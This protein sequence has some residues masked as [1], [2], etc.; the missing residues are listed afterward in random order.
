MSSVAGVRDA[1]PLRPLT[2]PPPDG[3]WSGLLRERCDE[4]LADAAVHAAALKEAPRGDLRVLEIWNDLQIDLGAAFAASTLFAE[5]HP[6]P[7]V[8]A[9][10]ERARQEAERFQ[11]DLMLDADV[12]DQLSLLDPVSLEQ[13]DGARRVVDK[14]LQD[15]RRA[16]V[17][18]DKTTRDR[19]RAI[20]EREVELEQAFSRGIREGTRTTRVPSSALAGLPEDW[21]AEHPV[22]DDGLVEVSSHYPD[23]FPFLTYSADAAARLAVATAHLNVGWPDN[24]PVLQELLTLRREHA[25]LLGYPDWPSFDAETKMIG[26]GDAIPAFIDRIVEATGGT[27]AKEIDRLRDL[28]ARHGEPDLVIDSSNWRYWS[29]RLRTEEYDVDAHEV[30]SYFDFAR[31]RQ[32]LLDVTGRLFGLTYAAVPDAPVWHAEVTAYDV[33]MD[34]DRVGRIYLDLHPRPGKYNHAAQFDLVRG[35]AGRHL[36]EGVLVCN[37]PRGQMEHS[38]VVTLFHEFGHLL[39]H[40][41]GGHTDWAR[42]SGVATEWDFVEAPSQMLEEWAWAPEV[43]STF[44]TDAEGRAIPADLVRRMRAAHDF[45]KGFLARQQMFYALVSY[46]FHQ[47]VPDD[48]TARMREIAR[49]VN[50]IALPDDTHF[51]AGFGHLEGYT[52]AYYTYMWSLVIAK[53]LFSAFDPEDLFDPAVAHRYRDK[54]LVPG[55]SRDAADLVRDFLGRP[56]NADAFERWIAG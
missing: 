10:A 7:D 40:V 51:H 6:D 16:G 48:L 35:V 2:L 42:F 36:P 43:L 30:R 11:T 18:R 49:E 8:R 3:D 1:S 54:V 17:D 45:G 32:G 28:A 27:G 9:Q 38:D 26:S 39:H 22:R 15:F 13:E 50:L 34:G 24:E 41:L 31:V 21:V 19:L 20:K 55:G 23:T 25:H 52:S 14:A 29:E 37:F 47:E 12:F 56:Y 53:D 33:L 5:V 44:A 4:R 46:R